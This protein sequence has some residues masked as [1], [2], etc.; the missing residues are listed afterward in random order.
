MES[1][2]RSLRTGEAPSTF[3]VPARGKDRRLAA[4]ER[5]AA[6]DRSADHR[7]VYAGL[8]A[9]RDEAGPFL[10]RALARRRMKLAASKLQRPP[11]SMARTTGRARAALENSGYVLSCGSEGRDQG[12]VDSELPPPPQGQPVGYDLDLPLI[13]SGR[14]EVEVSDQDVARNGSPSLP[15]DASGCAFKRAATRPQH[16]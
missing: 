10:A 1:A 8:L 14:D 5:A 11:T 16:A 15:A 7:C 13:L 6:N 4:K 3:A 12:G 2:K 9:A